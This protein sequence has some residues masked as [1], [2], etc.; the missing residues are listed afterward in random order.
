MNVTLDVIFGWIFSIAGFI[1]FGVSLNQLRK[2]SNYRFYQFSAGAWLCAG[3]N[4]FLYG[5]GIL[6]FSV[7]LVEIGFIAAEIS[8][9]FTILC[10]DTLKREQVEPVKLTIIVTLIAITIIALA[11]IPNA[12]YPYTFPLG[13]QGYYPN[14]IIGLMLVAAGTI[15][16]VYYFHCAF[17]VNKQ[18]PTALKKYSRIYA[19]GVFLVLCA[20]LCFVITQPF[21][22]GS[23]FLIYSVGGLL[24]AYAY[25]SEPKLIFIL[26]F[27]ALRLTVHN[28]VSGISLFTHTWNPQGDLVEENLFSG[29]LQGINL[30]VKESLQRGN[31]QELRVEGAILIAYRIPEFP[32]AFML[33]ATRPTQ[34]L[35]DSLKLFAENF[36][37]Q[38]RNQLANPSNVTDVHQ[39]RE[40]EALVAACFPHVPVY[41]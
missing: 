3:I 39:Y 22:P 2:G 19:V 17:L 32:V 30:I 21:L 7:E 11:M 40:A 37:R 6:V 8:C 13:D 29:M 25:G 15:S 33:V 27:K 14:V 4:G 9:L 36:C 28:T 34:S 1:G 12:I 5:L 18:A 23:S 41:T 35:R 10:A 24:M 20:T 26:P 38:F 16:F 31:L